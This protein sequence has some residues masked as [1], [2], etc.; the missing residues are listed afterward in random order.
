[1]SKH[2]LSIRYNIA[3]DSHRYT[4]RTIGHQKKLNNKRLSRKKQETKNSPHFQLEYI[5]AV[6]RAE[7][8]RPQLRASATRL[9]CYARSI[10]VYDVVIW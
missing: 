2:E 4:S 10:L 1:M 5:V 9:R 8:Q 7:Y 6:R 3:V